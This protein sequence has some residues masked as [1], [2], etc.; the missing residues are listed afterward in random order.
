MKRI[1][2][3][4]FLL[5]FALISCDRNEALVKTSVDTVYDDVFETIQFNTGGGKDTVDIPFGNCYLHYVRN[6]DSVLFFYRMEP[7]Y[8]ALNRIIARRSIIVKP[9]EIDPLK[10]FKYFEWSWFSVELKDDKVYIS[11]KEN[12]TG[13]ERI[14][15]VIIP[16]L[17]SRIPKVRRLE[18]KICQK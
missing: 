5:L 2:I 3:V 18:I 9:T 4:T 1:A 6:N 7:D 8:A 15:E 10:G 11:V 14:A 12:K 13:S 17:D 16:D